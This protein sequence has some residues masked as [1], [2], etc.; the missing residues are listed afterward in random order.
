MIPLFYD[1]TMSKDLP[2]YIFLLNAI[3]LFVY[4]TLD[5]IDGKNL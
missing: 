2:S 3:I 5:A 4:Q 1:L